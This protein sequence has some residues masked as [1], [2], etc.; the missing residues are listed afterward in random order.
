[1]E[2]TYL[3][4]MD[5]VVPLTSKVCIITGVDGQAQKR[6]FPPFLYCPLTIYM[7]KNP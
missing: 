1:M 6:Y 5:H 4:F 2:T 7:L 3:V